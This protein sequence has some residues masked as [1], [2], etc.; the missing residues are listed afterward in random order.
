M[1]FNAHQRTSQYVVS[2]GD[3]EKA[4]FMNNKKKDFDMLTSS[5]L[6]EQQ[7]HLLASL[8]FKAVYDRL[9]FI[10]SICLTLVSGILAILLAQPGMYDERTQTVFTIWIAV[11]ASISVF[12]QSLMK[13]LNYSGRAS[14]H[15]STAIALSRIYKLAK[16]R[17]REQQISDS[18][19]TYNNGSKNSEQIHGLESAE[20]GVSLMLGETNP[21]G[22]TKENYNSSSGKSGEDHGTLSKQFD[23]A[24]QGCTSFVPIKVT[25]AFDSLDSR[26]NVCNKRLMPSACQKPK[27][28]WE[29]VYPALYHQLTLTIIGSKLWPYSAPEAGWAVDEAIKDFQAQDACLLKVLINRTLEIDTQYGLVSTRNLS[30]DTETSPLLSSDPGATL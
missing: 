7:K 4:E 22:T 24:L 16:M 17:S 3:R 14:L 8:H 28:A 30:V 13:Q 12:W 6:M 21:D 10:P 9:L 23:Q 18:D 2:E 15:D 11:L 20:E 5:V 29:K 27:V 26:I 1:S 25:A 19:K